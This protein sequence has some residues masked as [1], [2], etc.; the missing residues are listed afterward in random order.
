LR[1]V[2]PGKALASG[3]PVRGS[4]GKGAGRGRAVEGL[5]ARQTSFF[6]VFGSGDTMKIVNELLSVCDSYR[7]KSGP[8]SRCASPG[9][10]SWSMRRAVRDIG[11][12]LV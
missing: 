10:S 5:P 2:E 4:P 6:P 1:A 12:V 3:W 8:S 11:S 7:R 9:R